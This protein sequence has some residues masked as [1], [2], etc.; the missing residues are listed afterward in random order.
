MAARDEIYRK[1]IQDDPKIVDRIVSLM[2]EEMEARF[3]N[4]VLDKLS[5]HDEHYNSKYFNMLVE[6][7]IDELPNI[8]SEGIK[9]KPDVSSIS[10]DEDVDYQVD[11]DDDSYDEPED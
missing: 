11:S 1:L 7:L 9:C 2:P 6:F 4:D 5:L 10:M 8:G 3:V